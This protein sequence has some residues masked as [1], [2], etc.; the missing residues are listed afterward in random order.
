MVVVAPF[1]ATQAFL[2][3]RDRIPVQITVVQ[4][5][6]EVDPVIKP[7]ETYESYVPGLMLRQCAA[8]GG[9]ALDDGV[10]YSRSYTQP[11]LRRGGGHRQRV[12]YRLSPELLALVI[13]PLWDPPSRSP[14]LE[15]ICG[16]PKQIEELDSFAACR[17]SSVRGG[18]WR[19]ET[20][21]AH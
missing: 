17:W 10:G 2:L 3:D 4:A 9:A 8:I 18:W 5:G 20:N 7:P 16:S 1:T 21:V 19:D 15:A 6:Q 13:G 12:H 14:S 11:G